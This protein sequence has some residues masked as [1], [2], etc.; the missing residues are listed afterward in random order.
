A[1]LTVDGAELPATQNPVDELIGIG[2]E[3]L[4]AAYGKLRHAMAIDLLGRVVVAGV[5]IQPGTERIDNCAAVAGCRGR[6]GVL[7]LRPCVVERDLIIPAQ[8][9]AGGH[10]QA[11]VIAG[12]DGAISEQR[13]VLRIEESVL[14]EFAAC[15]SAVDIDVVKRRRPVAAGCFVNVV[16]RLSGCERAG[17]GAGP[18]VLPE[19]NV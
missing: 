7:T 2:Q 19:G 1:C 10:V 3:S 14:S 13:N 15:G 6:S 18:E 5:V 17:R 8:A 16:D 11:V 4:P 9:L 12:A